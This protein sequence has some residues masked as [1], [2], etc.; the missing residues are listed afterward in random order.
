[1]RDGSKV[2]V[3]GFWRTDKG[4]F[5]PRCRPSEREN[6]PDLEHTG[7]LILSWDSCAKKQG[8]E[9]RISDDS[10][11]GCAKGSSWWIPGLISSLSAGS[12]RWAKYKIY[13]GQE[14]KIMRHS[15]T[16]AGFVP[17]SSG[18]WGTHRKN[19]I[20]FSPQSRA[21]SLLLANLS[22][23][24]ISPQELSLLPRRVSLTNSRILLSSAKFKGCQFPALGKHQASHG[25]L[26]QDRW[27]ANGHSWTPSVATRSLFL[28]CSRMI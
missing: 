17:C 12:M 7:C 6:S 5:W 18:P 20:Y 14:R 16:R 21:P 19:I 15:K 26:L 13:V 9:K 10:G 8:W 11:T 22:N 1:M 2:C 27:R 23:A 4:G 24:P 25:S 28:F 3:Y